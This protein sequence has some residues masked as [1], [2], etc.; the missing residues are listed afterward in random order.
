MTDP[1]GVPRLVMRAISGIAILTTCFAIMANAAPVVLDLSRSHSVEDLKRSGLRV[2][3]IA[4][5]LHGQAYSFQNQEVEILLPAGRSFRQK[6]ALGTI[7]TRDSQLT[8]LSMYGGVMPHD[9]AIQVMRMFLESFDLS[10]TPFDEWEAQN[11]GKIRNAEPYSASANLRFYPRVSLGLGPSMNGLYPWVIE[12]LISWD[13]DKQRDWNEER[14]WRELPPP[15]V[16][17]ISLN[18][19]SGQRYERGDAYKET[20]EA[21]AQFEKELAAKGSAPTPTM[22]PVTSAPTPMPKASPVVQAEQSKSFPWSWIIGA[23]LLLAVAG[24]IFMKFLRK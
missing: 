15:T 17:S 22:T 11:R 24:G 5:G 10:V 6:V 16:A 14:A 20:L 18:P 2:K 19:P 4:G 7:D 9:E 21:Q 3:E 1:Y 23:I 13:W 12:L 8:R